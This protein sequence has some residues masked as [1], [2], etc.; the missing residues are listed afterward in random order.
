[1]TPDEQIEAMRVDMDSVN[2][3]LAKATRM[4]ADE[5]AAKLNSFGTVSGQV[6]ASVQGSAGELSSSVHI[7]GSGAVLAAAK[8]VKMSSD[9]LNKNVGRTTGAGQE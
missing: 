8:A 1:M 6:S 7:K 5:V 4:T 2:E 9:L 3:A